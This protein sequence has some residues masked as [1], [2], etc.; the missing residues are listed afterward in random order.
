M[1]SGPVSC[2]LLKRLVSITGEQKWKGAQKPPAGLCAQTSEAESLQNVPS[3]TRSGKGRAGLEPR[4]QERTQDE[5]PEL[6]SK[7]RGGG[8]SQ[9]QGADSKT[10]TEHIKDGKFQPSTQGSGRVHPAWDG[11]TT[12]SVA[13]PGPSIYG[14]QS[15]VPS[16]L[17]AA[18]QAH[19]ENS[20]EE[21][22][23]LSCVHGAFNT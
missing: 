7:T 22:P 23:V 11:Q 12:V 15:L 5:C 21:R 14:G 16:D 9:H 8:R 3:V 20:R 1:R 4:P 19:T 18:G 17:S 6:V 13:T 10:A 2:F